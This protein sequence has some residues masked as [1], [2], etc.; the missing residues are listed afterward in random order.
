VADRSGPSLC[1][2]FLKRRG[3]PDAPS[4]LPDTT[5]GGFL[6]V[7]CKAPGGGGVPPTW[8]GGGNSEPRRQRLGGR[9]AAEKEQEAAR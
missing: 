6:A 4:A 5:L 8:E 3:L 7:H 9:G 1:S 2:S